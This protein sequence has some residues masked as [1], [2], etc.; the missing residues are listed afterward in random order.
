MKILMKYLKPQKNQRLLRRPENH[1][2]PHTWA[3]VTSG[4]VA[5]C[6]LRK[7]WEKEKPS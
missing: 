2:W 3:R 7:L 1:H 6:C 4:E 5:V